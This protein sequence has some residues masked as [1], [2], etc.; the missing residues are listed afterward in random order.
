MYQLDDEG[1]LITE[2]GEFIHDQYG[3][4]IYFNQEN[5][6]YLKKQNFV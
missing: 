1:Y 4:K 3:E 6:E 5:I 2:E